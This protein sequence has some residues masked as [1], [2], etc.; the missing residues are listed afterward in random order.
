[1]AMGSPVGAVFRAM[2]ALLRRENYA[3]GANLQDNMDLL[4]LYLLTNARDQWPNPEQP[5]AIHELPPA[6]DQREIEIGRA[7][8]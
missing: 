3:S 8:V 4:R 1:M 5:P 6:R 7:H 2:K